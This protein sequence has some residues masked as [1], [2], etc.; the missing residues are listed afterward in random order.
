MASFSSA[1]RSCQLLL[2]ARR[3]RHRLSSSP[4]AE[5][6]RYS[7]LCYSRCVA[8]GVAGRPI[9]SQAANGAQQAAARRPRRV[10]FRYVKVSST[11]IDGYGVRR[12]K[13]E[14]C[15]LSMAVAMALGRTVAIA[16]G[17]GWTA[18][19]ERL[20]PSAHTHTLQGTTTH[21]APPPSFPFLGVSLV[22]VCSLISGAIWSTARYSCERLRQPCTRALPASSLC[23][24]TS[25]VDEVSKHGSYSQCERCYA[26]L[27]G[28]T[29][30][31]SSLA[32]CVA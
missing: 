14:S 30:S 2:A 26:L 5:I 19:V 29:A 31:M 32:A 12:V 6:G 27:R 11:G 13:S 21:S 15:C 23:Y 28:R 16:N 9:P 25:E 17:S 10:C 4:T 1:R 22:V 24:R 8:W 20:E 18:G 3:R 7:A